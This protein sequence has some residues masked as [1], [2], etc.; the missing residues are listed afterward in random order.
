[1]NEPVRGESDLRALLLAPT[2]R[3]GITGRDLLAEAGI[4]CC[5]CR[6]LDEICREIPRGAGV[7]LV[8]EESLRNE[9]SATFLDMLQAQP[10]WSD[11]PVIV[12]M[13]ARRAVH[14]RIQ[15]L[16]DLG[17]VTLVKRPL[18]VA[19]FIAA[20][21]SALRDR[22]RQY[23]V[24]DY[25]MEHARQAE[26][27]LD[28][29]RRKDEF[30]AMLAHELRNPLAPIRNGLQILR[31][32]E[33]DLTL[34]NETREMMDRQVNH[35]ARLV[36]DLLDISR[37]TRG[38]VDLRKEV[39]DLVEILARAVE[40]ARPVIDGGRHR[41]VVSQPG[42]PVWITADAV[43]ITQV[44]GNLLNNAAK[45]SDQEGEIR[46]SLEAEGPHA[47]VRVKDTGVGIPTD[48]LPSVFELFI[49]IDRTLDRSQGGLGI[50]LTLVRTLVEMHGGTAAAFSEGLGHGSEFVVK[51]PRSS[52]EEIQQRQSHHKSDGQL[53]SHHRILVVDDNVDAAT[54]LAMLLQLHGHDVQTVNNGLKVLDAV[55]AFQPDVALLDI[56]LPGIDGYELARRIR[57][58]QAGQKLLLIALTGYGQEEDRRRTHEAGF[59]HH[60]TKPADPNE[61]Q[62]LLAMPRVAN[63]Q[64]A[65]RVN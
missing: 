62:Q 11:L 18:D 21:R 60:L 10:N 29:D 15:S 45:Y 9:Q 17:G 12:L 42:H 14:R 59:D 40:T 32:A 65:V 1:M 33:N 3:D 25:L 26:A 37:I 48:M 55:A 22:L 34:V 8:P 28:A 64:D 51:L 49:Q 4:C 36:D 41:L 35:L 13:P 38:K 46:L 56:G 58:T 16:I 47:V 57:Q 20:V 54:S 61:I 30:L 5:I 50:G 23:Q 24:Q 6:N 63:T 53:I 2:A 31:M 39:V 43:R 52:A 7:V 27:L 44:V 19:A